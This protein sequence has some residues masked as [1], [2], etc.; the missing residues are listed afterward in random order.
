M[1]KAEKLGKVV[2][3]YGLRPTTEAGKTVKVYTSVLAPNDKGGF[4]FNASVL[5][6]EATVD[7]QVPGKHNV[8]NAL[9]AL[10]VA[11]LLDLRL[12]DAALALGQFTGT[13]RR[14]EVRGE[15]NGIVVVDDYAHH[16]TEIRVTL[17]AARTRYPSRRI[18]AVWQ[19]HTYSRTQTL[20]K[21]F[22]DAFTDA[23]EV[24]VTE[25][26]AAREA[27]Q[28]FSSK[29]VVEAMSRPAHFIAG[30]SEVSNYLNTNL[31]PGDVLLVLSAG[32]ADEISTE[33]LTHLKEVRNG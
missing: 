6:N 8:S 10:T 33:V 24:I 27:K 9:A 25:I 20:L 14:F 32:D 22:A 29:K 26:Y 28:A 21:E 12:Q 5:G 4:R 23:D 7:L 3:P 1:D 30:L 2:I 15:A 18:W 31:R 11:H 13:R 16:P 17:A 19:P